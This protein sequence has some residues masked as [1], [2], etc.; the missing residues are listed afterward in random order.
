MHGVYGLERFLAQHNRGLKRIDVL[1]QL[2]ERGGS[3]DG[4]SVESAR[5][6]PVKRHGGETHTRLIGDFFVLLRHLL[7]SLQRVM[8]YQP[9]RA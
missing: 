9:V 6:A 7:T 2:L 3:D 1:L 5:L 8:N 4:G